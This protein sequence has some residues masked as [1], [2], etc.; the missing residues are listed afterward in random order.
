MFDGNYDVSVSYKVEHKKVDQDDDNWRRNSL[1]SWEFNCLAMRISVFF[2]PRLSTTRWLLLIISWQDNAKAG[3]WADT[4][5]QENCLYCTTDDLLMSQKPRQWATRERR[6][7]WANNKDHGFC[8]NCANHKFMKWRAIERRQG[9]RTGNWISE[10][11]FA[12][13]HGMREDFPEQILFNE[14]WNCNC[15]QYAINGICSWM[16]S[17]YAFIVRIV[18]C[19]RTFFSKWSIFKLKDCQLNA[20][21]LNYE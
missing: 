11:L 17:S 14:K 8:D 1:P 2:S 10:K 15:R 12:F 5:G 6:R 3:G 18:F 21:I 13:R 16:A 19:T 20:Q 9:I 7:G 4:K